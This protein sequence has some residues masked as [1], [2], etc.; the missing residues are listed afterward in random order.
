MSPLHQVVDSVTAQAVTPWQILGLHSVMPQCFIYYTFP[1][2]N[3]FHNCNIA[4]TLPNVTVSCRVLF[5]K[6]DMCV[7][8]LVKTNNTLKS[9][10]IIVIDIVHC[11]NVLFG[12]YYFLSCLEVPYVLSIWTKLLSFFILSVHTLPILHVAITLIHINQGIKNV[13]WMHTSVRD[14]LWKYNPAV[15]KENSLM[16]GAIA[17]GTNLMILD[18]GSGKGDSEWTWVFSVVL[19]M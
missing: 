16:W 10:K 6:I 3:S 14:S 5:Y 19:K 1:S 17:W 18:A 4:N 9:A 11:Q 2:S 12:K 15:L 7:C 8:L 13:G